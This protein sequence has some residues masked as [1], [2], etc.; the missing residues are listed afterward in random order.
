MSSYILYL[1]LRVGGASS[2]EWPGYLVAAFRWF[3]E[4]DGASPK[5][6]AREKVAEALAALPMLVLLDLRLLL[7]DV[8][9]PVVVMPRDPTETALS[10]SSERTW[11]WWW[12]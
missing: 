11:Y 9:D 7:G 3:V 8:P 10:S 4:E 5:P 1:F 6:T 2:F 12:W